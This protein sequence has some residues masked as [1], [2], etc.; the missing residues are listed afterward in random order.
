MTVERFRVR[1]CLRLGLIMSARSKIIL[2]DLVLLAFKVFMY[3]L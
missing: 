1:F 2:L 3:M